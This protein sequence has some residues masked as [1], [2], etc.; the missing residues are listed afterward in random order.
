MSRPPALLAVLAAASPAL[1]SSDV[2]GWGTEV[3]DTRFHRQTFVQVVAGAQ[4][5]VALRPD[6]TIAAWGQN[7]FGE[8][9]VPPLP[10][11]LRYVDVD[12][13]GDSFAY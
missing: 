7:H 3:V 10:P 12:C 13:G 4:Q 9:V 6:G 5:T 11:G 8:C 2:I 1:A